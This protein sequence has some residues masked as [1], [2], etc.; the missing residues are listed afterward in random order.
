[1]KRLLGCAGPLHRAKAAVLMTNPLRTRAAFALV[2]AFWLGLGALCGLQAGETNAVS[3]RSSVQVDGEGVSLSQVVQSEASLPEL[4][5][6]DA[7][8]FGKTS[9]LTRSQ[10]SEALRTA[11]ADLLITNWAGAEA[12]RISRRARALTESE[13]LELLTSTLQQQCVKDKGELELRLSRPWTTVTVPDEPF[14][15]RILDLPTAGVTPAFITRFELQTAR[16]E[17]V[18]SWQAA[19]QARVWRQIWVARSTLK[20]G[21]LL[22]EADMTRERRDVLVCH[23]NLAEFQADDSS[24]ELAEPV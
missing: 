11:G 18:G 2:A 8:A 12:V 22:R 7:P 20:R 21:E 9:Q 15:L 3:L 13:A 16:G 24:L 17:R 1:M 10:I 6:A 23:E 5:L 4:R 19:L 14:T